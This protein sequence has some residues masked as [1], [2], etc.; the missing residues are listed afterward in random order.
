[1]LV[2]LYKILY[3][4]MH[5]DSYIEYILAF[6]LKLSYYEKNNQK[7]VFTFCLHLPNIWQFL[8]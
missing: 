5:Q 1:M 6:C 4:N 2:F 8:F 7:F 3:K